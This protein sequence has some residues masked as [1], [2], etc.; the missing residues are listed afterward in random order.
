M[1][2]QP[3]HMLHEPRPNTAAEEEYGW[4]ERSRKIIRAELDEIAR[5]YPIGGDTH[6]EN[7]IS[8]LESACDNIWRRMAEL[9][10][11][12]ASLGPEVAA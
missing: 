1:N 5:S 10:D 6:I 4:L 11:G 3:L 2:M 12:A 7:A 9:D 8:N